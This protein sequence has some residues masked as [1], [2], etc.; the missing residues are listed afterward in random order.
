MTGVQTCALPISA[1]V[2]VGVLASERAR[3]FPAAR[4][5]ALLVVVG[6]A[7]LGPYLVSLIS[8]G[9]RYPATG[10]PMGLWLGW[11]TAVF[12]TGIVVLYAGISAGDTLVRGRRGIP[13]W[14]APLL[15][16]AAGIVAPIVVEPRGGLPQWYTV[17]WVGAIL[18]IIVTR[19]SAATLWAAATV[20][21]FGAA[22]LV[23]SETVKARVVLAEQDVAGLG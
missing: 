10:A 19:R 18:A 16:M 15:A 23:W 11:E 21:A 22:T 3:L 7:V 9:I 6:V 17:A 5:R 1:T 4:S 14:V 13:A 8:R 20:A 12:L 2:L